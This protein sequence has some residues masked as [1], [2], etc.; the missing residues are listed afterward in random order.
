MKF[1]VFFALVCVEVCFVESARTTDYG[2][3]DSS[4]M[5]VE[6][7]HVDRTMFKIQNRTVTLPW[8]RNFGIVFFFYFC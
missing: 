6:N 2:N 3:V 8:V 4:A 5:N 1:F 7:I